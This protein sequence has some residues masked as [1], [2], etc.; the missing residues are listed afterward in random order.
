MIS[1]FGRGGRK[2]PPKQYRLLE[3]LFAA[4][5]LEGKIIA[6]DLSHFFHRTWQNRAV[7]DLE[8]SF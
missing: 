3:L 2:N 7:T 5:E 1:N 8:T 4:S 6:E